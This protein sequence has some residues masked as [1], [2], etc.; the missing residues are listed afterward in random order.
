MSLKIVP[1]FSSVSRLLDSTSSNTARAQELRELL[2]DYFLSQSEPSGESRDVVGGYEA[3]KNDSNVLNAFAGFKEEKTNEAPYG[4]GRPYKRFH[5]SEDSLLV[6]DDTM[7]NSG[8][9]APWGADYR[10]VGLPRTAPT[11]TNQVAA[12]SQYLTSAATLKFV[13]NWADT[14]NTLP[15]V[16]ADFIV[17]QSVNKAAPGDYSEFYDSPNWA[18]LTTQNYSK[19][20]FKKA[21]RYMLTGRFRVRMLV[22]D[23]WYDYQPDYDDIH[24]V[25]GSDINNTFSAATDITDLVDSN[26]MD[27]AF[28]MYRLKLV[29]I[30]KNEG[31]QT[32]VK[33]TLYSAIHYHG[34]SNAP[35]S[36]VV[37]GIHGHL[38][39]SANDEV[40]LV[41][42]RN[43]AML[44]YFSD[45][46]ANFDAVAVVKEKFRQSHK[47]N[48]D[49][50]NY[51]EISRINGPMPDYTPPAPPGPTPP[52]PTPPG[53]T[54]PTPPEPTPT[55]PPAPTPETPSGN[56][57]LLSTYYYLMKDGI[58]TDMLVSGTNA[59]GLECALSSNT[60]KKN[61]AIITKNVSS[62]QSKSFISG[63]DVKANGIYLANTAIATP[64][65]PGDYNFITSKAAIPAGDFTATDVFYFIIYQYTTNPLNR[66]N[67]PTLM[68]KVESTYLA[69]NS[70]ISLDKFDWTYSIKLYYTESLNFDTYMG[71]Q[72]IV[73]ASAT[74]SIVN[75][76]FNNISF[77]MTANM[78]GDNRREFG[79]YINDKQLLVHKPTLTELP[80]ASKIAPA[81]DF[82]QM[83]RPSLRIQD[84]S[85]VTL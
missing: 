14:S 48:R 1:A 71:A 7:A 80:F 59:A 69:G 15:N 73:I 2:F 63:I 42:E 12:D 25:V 62:S 13:D 58:D 46:D 74:G 19:L 83:L 67:V 8:V 5:T 76:N 57:S 38:E 47:P 37:V 52:T 22:T 81:F 84:Y 65:Y 26:E 28:P 85:Y 66:T 6:H 43:A 4:P 3:H 68:A 39:I 44:R 24:A 72:G 34:S 55:E 36:R 60:G 50:S 29:Q 82:S 20:V 40:L 78:M 11:G 79:F 61:I 21:G 10:L 16:A 75:T 27:Y 70:A 33:N 35:R 32:V 31:N 9:V 56:P 23:H 41:L 45:D 49:K 17:S 54:P 53:P 51:L 77:L 30:G 64:A 18:T